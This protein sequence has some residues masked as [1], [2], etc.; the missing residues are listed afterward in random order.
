M[1]HHLL[2]TFEVER[3]H[4]AII[5]EFSADGILLLVLLSE[6]LHVAPVH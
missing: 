4:L 5:S 3:A 6:P 1:S 2:R